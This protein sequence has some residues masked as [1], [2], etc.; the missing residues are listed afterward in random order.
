[1][2]QFLLLLILGIFPFST[3]CCTCI[4]EATIYQELKRSD[5]VF[6]GK[7]ISKEIIEFRD[8]LMTDVVIQKAKYTLSVLANFKGRI[9][10]ETITII[11][12]LGGGDCGFSF[13]IGKEYIVYSSFEKKYY[14]KGDIVS[15]F[16]Y[17]DICRRTRL[18]TDINEINLLNK[19][20]KR[21]KAFFGQLLNCIH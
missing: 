20:C 21:L 9:K 12:G 7:V 4:G 13:E 6:K 18:A 14:P 15:K 2:R 5:I 8:T 11:T 1:M 17:T 19:R 16:L 10:N 3:Y